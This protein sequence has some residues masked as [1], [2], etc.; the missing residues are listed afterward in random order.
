MP[1]AGICIVP[2]GDMAVR[3]F[4]ITDPGFPLKIQQTLKHTDLSGNSIFITALDIPGR[5]NGMI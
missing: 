3:S 1:P 5:A 4:K 2:L